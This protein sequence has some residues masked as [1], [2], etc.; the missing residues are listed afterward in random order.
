MLNSDRPLLSDANLDWNGAGIADFSS[1][2]WGRVVAVAL[3]GTLF[4]VSAALL[5]DSYNFPTMDA[6]E[7]ARALTVD[8]GLPTLL[9]VPMLSFL[10]AKLRELAITKHHLTI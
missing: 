1:V 3:A 9:A 5:V 6:A 8:I 10:M 4:S 2:G 7:F